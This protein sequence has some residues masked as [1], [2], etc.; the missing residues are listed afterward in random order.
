MDNDTLSEYWK[1]VSPI[2][3]EQNAK[4]REQNY[5][6]RIDYAIKQFE[7]NNIPFKLCNKE[8]GHF[9]LYKDNKVVMSFWSWTGKCYIP[10]INFSENI[11]LKN[12]IKKYKK[13]FMTDKIIIKKNIELL[14]E[15]KR[16]KNNWNDLKQFIK[17]KY[18]ETLNSNMFDALDYMHKLENRK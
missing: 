14:N 8:N 7:N 1:D 10:S 12:C 18:G 2:L 16:L 9:N 13:M 17:D 5:D 4:N 11:G 6:K 3:K 15:N